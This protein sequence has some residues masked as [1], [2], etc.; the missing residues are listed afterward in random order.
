MVRIRLGPRVRFSKLTASVHLV[1]FLSENARKVFES[2]PQ[3]PRAYFWRKMR[4]A[5]FAAR[6]GFEPRYSDSESEVLPLDDLAMVV[7]YRI[8]SRNG[9]QCPTASEAR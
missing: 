8:A 9:G 2:K 5:Y 4:Y 7:L 6:L 3:T 1:D